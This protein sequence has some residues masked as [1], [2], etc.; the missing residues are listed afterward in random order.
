MTWPILIVIGGLAMRHAHI[1]TGTAKW[2]KVIQ[3]NGLRP[4]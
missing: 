2:T 3:D 1:A 4:D